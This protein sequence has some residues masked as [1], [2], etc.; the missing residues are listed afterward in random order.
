MEVHT[1]FLISFQQ[2][3]KIKN[4]KIFLKNNKK[5]NKTK[6][7]NKAK[8]NKKQNKKTHTNKKPKQN[9]I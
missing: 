5:Q 1:I 8:T 2:K 7:K 6:N 3:L 4:L 9:V